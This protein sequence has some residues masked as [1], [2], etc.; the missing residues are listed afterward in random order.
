MDTQVQNQAFNKFTEAAETINNAEM[1]K[2]K[3]DGKGIIG[4]FC[5]SFPEEIITA[6][7]MMPFRIRATGSEDTELSDSFFSSNNCSFPRHA[8]NLALKGEFDFLDGIIVFNS[9][10]NIRRIYDHWQRQLKTPFVEFVHIPKKA[11]A[12]QVDWFREEMSIFKEKVESHFNLELTDDKLAEAIKTH[13]ETRQLLRQLYDLRKGDSPPITGAETIAITVASTAMPKLTYNK[14]LK[15]LLKELNSA[16]GHSDYKARLMVIGGEL[17]NPGYIDVI[18]SQ[19]GLVVT[20]SLCFGTRIFWKDV[21][22]N[23]EDPLTALSQYYIVE[24]PSCPRVYGKHADRAGYVKKMIED[25]KVDGVIFE[26]LAFCDIWGFEQF[27]ITNDFKEW[28]VPLLSLDREY[29]LTAIGQ[30][31]TRVQAFMEALGG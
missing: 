16:K 14:L 10:D 30:L 11:E 27:S 21:D 25:F 31:R 23:I 29:T 18:E 28:N 5:S 24:R 13:N 22:E 15:D 7:G 26:R 4:Y 12:A 8:F 9:C 1:K 2:W 20:D 19:G 6:A 3:N 17:D